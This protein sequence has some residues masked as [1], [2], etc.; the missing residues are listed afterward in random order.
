MAGEPEYREKLQAMGSEIRARRES[1]GLS[2]EDA[3]AKTKLRPKYLLAVEAGDDAEAPGATYFKAFIKTYSTFLGLDGSSYSAALQKALEERDAPQPRQKPKAVQPLVD[4]PSPPLPVSEKTAKLVEEPV[5]PVQSAPAQSA[6][7]D[8]PRHVPQ[9]NHKA[10]ADES[11]IPLVP[12][13]TSGGPA[14]RELPLHRPTRSKKGARPV[15]WLFLLI[16]VVSAGA[17]FAVTLRE[18]PETPPVATT[19]DPEPTTPV[20]TPDPEPPPA[21][22]VVRTEVSPEQVTFTVDR[23]PVELTI[24]T[25]KGEDSYCWVRVVADGELVFERT[26]A[27]DQEEKVSAES[28]I[29]IR[30]GKPWVLSLDINEQDQGLAGEFGPVKDIT[31]TRAP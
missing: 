2:I 31:I 19:P 28:E 13:S 23:T 12:V 10:P 6:A 1:L 21:P 15:L 7:T 3:S 14:K 11:A 5:A 26:L 30:A 24:R 17:Y 16:F 8:G 25:A 20:V 9:P 18:T 27:P 29:S 4:K 22:K